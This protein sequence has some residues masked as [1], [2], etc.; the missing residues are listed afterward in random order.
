MDLHILQ[1][2][3][4]SL[5]AAGRQAQL[6]QF[7]AE[8]RVPPSIIC[9]QETFLKPSDNFSF[10]GYSVVQRC[11]DGATRGGGVATFIINGLSFTELKVPQDIEAVSI[12]FKLT[13]KRKMTVTNVY[14]VPSTPIP[15]DNFKELF[16]PRNN[17]I[18]GDFNS[19]ST[20]W[21]SPTTDLNGRK[22][23]KLLDDCD[24]SCINTG[25]GTYEKAQGRGFSHLDL[26]FVSRSL[27]ARSTW[28]VIQDTLGSDHLPVLTS[29]G[30]RPVLENNELPR[31]N[32]KRA[33]WELFTSHLD[34][35]PDQLE[36]DVSTQKAYTQL[37][38]AIIGAAKMS[39]PKQTFRTK[40]TP[41]PYWSTACKEAIKVRN[42]ARHRWVRRRYQ[43]NAAEYHNEYKRLKGIAQCTI[44]DAGRSH[45]EAYCSSLSSASKLSSVWKMAK[46]MSGTTTHESM[47]NLVV[48]K[49][50]DK[51]VFESNH[52]KANLLAQTYAEVSSDQHYE[53]NFRNHKAAMETKWRSEAP[54]PC[55]ET[56][57]ALDEPISW[58]ELR[59]AIENCKR[60]SAP[61]PDT[62]SY[63]MVRHIPLSA[64]QYILDLFNR[65]WSESKLVADWK[66]ALVIPIPKP[67]ATKSAPQSYRPIA[68]TAVFC[69]LFERILVNRLEWFL[70]SKC[71]LNKFQSGFR[72]QR[73][74]SDHIA[75]LHDSVHKA[76]HTKQHTLAI[77]LDFSKA[78][79]MVWRE[80]LLYKLRNLGIGGRMYS[81]IA[82]FLSDRKIRVKVGAAISDIYSLDNG[83]PQGSIIS[84][85]LFNIM[86]NDLP[87]PNKMNITPAIFADDY[88]AW[89][90]GKNHKF[91]CNSVQKHLNEITR[92]TET[93]GFKLNT[94][95]SVA[96]F[97][98][99][100]TKLEASV[101]LTVRGVKL[102]VV[103]NTKFLGVTFDRQLSW[104][105]HISNVVERTKKAYNLMR[106]V[107]GHSWGASKKA[108]I[109]IYKA[110]VRSRLDYGCEAVYTAGKIQ[111]RRL[112]NVQSKCLRLCCCAFRSTAVNALQQDCGEM[113]LWIRRRRLLLRFA[114][115]VAANPCN[116]ASS[117]PKLDWQA[118]HAKI[119]YRTGQEPLNVI[120]QQYLAGS[121]RQAAAPR[122]LMA[123]PW[124]L[125]S[126][127]TDSAL[128]KL[129]SKKVASVESMK[130]DTLCHM[131]HYNNTTRIFT[132][133]SKTTDG[134]PRVAAAIYIENLEWGQTQRLND[135]A[136]IYAAELH[137][138]KT[139]TDW[140]LQHGRG[141]RATIF[142]DSLSAI[143]SLQSLCSISQ[144][145]SLNELLVSIDLL[146][147]PPTFVWI[148]SH[149]DIH[150]N[151]TADKLAKQGT[152]R[153]TIDDILPLEIQEEFG[154]IDVYSQGLWQN[155]YTASKTGNDYRTLEPLV[156]NRM[157]Y[158]TT[159]RRKENV[160]TR[161]RLG[162]C[163]L[164]QYLLAIKRHPDGLCDTCHVPE[165]IIHLLLECKSNGFPQLLT[166]RCNE[167]HLQPTLSNLLSTPALQDL[168]FDLILNTSR[169]L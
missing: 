71:L 18:V 68:L 112:D 89:Q 37:V 28:T 60:H 2:N 21:G 66:E 167:L 158:A 162:K 4:R 135:T 44:K 30:V 140:L 150:G 26:T 75:R 51:K 117:L 50:K 109:T 165:T 126:P 58:I 121:D 14:H 36:T 153:A 31:W 82:D 154:N 102:S 113:P 15:V 108:L 148:P 24:L 81:W 124:H 46:K 49:D 63:D 39:I 5:L 155:E 141:M 139:A 27:A 80:G 47:P 40:H 94:E 56:A 70:E 146:N 79:D 98:T 145:T 101:N 151:E 74:T 6:K 19:F 69:K 20:L 32:L 107:A 59:Q 104:K 92:W 166:T 88:A 110:L 142:T 43:D 48:G 84:P 17:V 25:E 10:P 96:V 97:F 77:F 118:T 61:G 144:S 57:A 55:S 38:D 11:R 16:A 93:W 100:N 122:R 115:K 85:L 137:A 111:L 41:L 125:K 147:P 106:S 134:A 86:I 67:G 164:N 103:P 78:F 157:K 120:L 136:S 29:I 168:V 138:I 129:F 131:D 169:I 152:K 33:N 116:P 127:L 76:K 99:T 114:V 123:P 13:S 3:C 95:K 90:S 8:A 65:I 143:Q 163:N 161:L 130:A 23:E 9:I 91:L 12:Q 159:N 128:T 133:A 132:D 73:G 35:L 156:S 160:I 42:A 83:T 119:P 149:V 22:L 45:W 87:H 72:K 53:T 105:T 7:I 34:V 52:D 62:I 54:P 64:Q 1:W